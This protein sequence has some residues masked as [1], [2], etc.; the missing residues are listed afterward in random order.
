VNRHTTGNR[1]KGFTLIE[2][3]ITVVIIA[4]L[5]AIAVPSYQNQ[6]QKTRRADAQGALTGLANAMERY[7]T[8]NNTYAGAAVGVGGIFPA[9]A[10]LDGNTKYYTL[11]IADADGDSYTLEATPIAGG[12]Q[13]GNGALRLTSTGVKTWDKDG[14]DSFAH[15]W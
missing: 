11:S 9:Q 4:I 13:D 6:V 10:P 5:A 2:L 15:A 8:N 12:A 3:M 1:V 14:D 7:F